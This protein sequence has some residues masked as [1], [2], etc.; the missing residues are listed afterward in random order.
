MANNGTRPQNDVK[1][2]K[3]T[4]TTVKVEASKEEAVLTIASA[5]STITSTKSIARGDDSESKGDPIQ[6]PSATTTTVVTTKSGRA[7]KPS[8][9]A[10]GSFPDPP[11]RSRSSR[12]ASTANGKR[13]HKKGAAQQLAARIADEDANG[14]VRGDEEGEVDADEPLYCYCNGVSYGEMV[15]CDADDC[16]REWFHLDCVGLRAAPPSNMKWYCDHCKDR[17]KSGKK[18]NGR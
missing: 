1:L 4:A 2:S 12:N 17:M 5:S 9:P 14:S 13:S 7:S 18:V 10:L 11:P 3:E 16:E 15:A 8:T 6:T